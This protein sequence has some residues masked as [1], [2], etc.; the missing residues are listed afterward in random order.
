MGLQYGLGH[1]LTRNAPTNGPR[2]NPDGPK[3]YGAT[4][5][6]VIHYVLGHKV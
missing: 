5:A 6:V 4:T 1:K 3:V 2:G